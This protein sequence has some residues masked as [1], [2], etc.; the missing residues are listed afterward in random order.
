[1]MKNLI[2]TTVML[3][4]VS[5]H[6]EKILVKENEKG[7][8]VKK[9]VI[10]TTPRTLRK[11]NTEIDIQFGRENS[12]IE[13]IEPKLNLLTEF[14]YSDLVLFPDEYFG[15]VTIVSEGEDFYSNL[16]FDSKNEVD[17]VLQIFGN[18]T[19]NGKTN[20]EE[21]QLGIPLDIAEKLR[22]TRID[23]I[24]EFENRFEFNVID[25]SEKN[26]RN[27]DDDLIPQFRDTIPDSN[28][29][30]LLDSIPEPND[31]FSINAQLQLL[32]SIIML[33]DLKIYENDQNIRIG[34]IT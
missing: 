24:L 19:E 14:S 6:F 1:M 33:K 8:I 23:S 12:S 30:E 32:D 11:L 34:S 16:I 31:S 18:Y 17:E 15:I 10:R 13:T 22:I 29:L 20:F 21:I 7:L 9:H 25:Q 2:L 28:Q 27:N 4:L 26:F 3:L 5:C